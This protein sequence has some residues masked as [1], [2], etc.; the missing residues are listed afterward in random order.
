MV[1]RF[2]LLVGMLV[3]VS[4]AIASLSAAEPQRGGVLR[5]H[6]LDLQNIDAHQLLGR[7]DDISVAF[8]VYDP[9][10][11]LDANLMPRPGLAESW[12]VVDDNTW[13][14]HLRHGVM[15]QDGNEVFPEGQSREVIAD[16]V[17][18]SINRAKELAGDLDLRAITSVRA[19]DKYTVEVK[20]AY[21]D[22]FLLDLH[23]LGRLMIVPHEAVEQLGEDFSL[24]PVG[25]GPFEIVSFI[26]G[27]KA[28]LRRNEDYWLPVYLDGVEFQV[29]PDPETTRIALETGAIDLVWYVRNLETAVDLAQEGFTV[30]PMGYSY[31]G[32]GFNV[33]KP[34]FDDWRVRMALSMMLDIDSAIKAVIP[35]GFGERAY[36]QVPPNVPMGYDPEGLRPLHEYNPD[37]GLRLLA[38]A[39]WA[40]S[41]G[42][43][44]LDKD[45]ERLT[46]PIEI[47]P[48]P[49][50]IDVFTILVTQLRNLGI[51][52]QL[53]QLD[54]SVWVDHLLTGKGSG[55]FFDFSYAGPTGLYSL[56]HSAT[57]GAS[58]THFY[59]NPV[60]DY[61]L[62]RASRTLD[63][64]KRSSFWKR[65]Q[66]IIIEDRVIIPVYFEASPA[67]ANPKVHDWDASGG[68]VRLVTPDYSAWIE[69]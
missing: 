52:A 55:I 27:E 36:G 8:Q 31:R 35:E 51:D 28:V 11:H 49:T 3:L 30:K 9:L 59:S 1:K 22:A 67:A 43:G 20:T 2:T 24:R 33:T 13:I 56:F 69:Q 39:G 18:Y 54:T 21:P 23:H 41:D 57:I 38:A 34:P 53:Q 32:I 58:N 12:E 6:A 42:D 60:V 14:F 61:L 63:F 19:L 40:D 45:G 62:D 47:Y 64:D 50:G 65:A 4:I 17:V 66:R 37:E 10:I 16:D 25:S 44:F 29:I 26:P 7:N 5:I 48:N 68:F 15:F 46:I